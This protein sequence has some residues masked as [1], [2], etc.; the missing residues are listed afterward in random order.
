MRP[1]VVRGGL[2][3]DMVD[4]HDLA[5][6]HYCLVLDASALLLDYSDGRNKLVIDK[7]EHHDPRRDVA[8]DNIIII[9]NDNNALTN[10]GAGQVRDSC[11]MRR[12]RTWHVCG[13]EVRV[14]G[15]V[16]GDIVRAL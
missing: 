9:I 15:G 13:W 5:E 4:D 7:R 12:R 11:R 3:L 14:L 2:Q 10:G 8:L 16:C 1:R 6:S